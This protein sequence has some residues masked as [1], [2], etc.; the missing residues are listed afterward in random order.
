MP[1]PLPF[2]KLPLAV[3]DRAGYAR[4]LQLSLPVRRGGFHIRPGR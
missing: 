1:R 2:R 3:H 4:L